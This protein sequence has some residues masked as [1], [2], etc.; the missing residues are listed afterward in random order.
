MAV[1]HLNLSAF[2]CFLL[3]VSMEKTILICE[4]CNQPMEKVQDQ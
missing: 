2:E 4:N 3:S 1:V